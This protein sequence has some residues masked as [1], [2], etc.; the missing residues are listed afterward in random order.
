MRNVDHSGSGNRRIFEAHLQRFGAERDTSVQSADSTTVTPEQLINWARG[1]QFRL[2]SVDGGHTAEI[3]ASD[4]A[5]ADAVSVDSGILI[6]DD[7]FNETWPGVSEG[8]N[9]YLASRRDLIGIGSA[10]GKSFFTRS[11][12]YADHYRDVMRKVGKEQSWRVSEQPFF[13]YPHVA[14]VA[15]PRWSRIRRTAAS[16]AR[17]VPLPKGAISK[18][19]PRG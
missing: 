4:M 10:H 6:L 11:T 2:F 15:Q 17:Q 14:L 5:L 1:T 16:A 13:G 12:E 8:A 18:I 3:T 7:Y 9:R 19:R